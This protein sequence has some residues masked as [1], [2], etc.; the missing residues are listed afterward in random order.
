M[1]DVIRKE[2]TLLEIQQMFREAG[3]EYFVTYRDGP[4]V[5]INFCVQEED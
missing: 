2:M 1:T 4:I 3:L 5:S